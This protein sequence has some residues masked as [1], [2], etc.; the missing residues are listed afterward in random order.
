MREGIVCAIRILLLCLLLLCFLLVVL[1]KMRLRAECSSK[2][3]CIIIVLLR[4]LLLIL[5]W[6]IF[7][8][9]FLVSVLQELVMLSLIICGKLRSLPF[10]KILSCLIIILVHILPC[11][12]FPLLLFVF[13]LCSFSLTV[14]IVEIF[15][16]EGVTLS[17]SLQ[18]RVCLLE[19]L[20]FFLKRERPVKTMMLCK[21]Y[22]RRYPG[23][24]GDRLSLA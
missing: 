9:V 7:V 19:L 11:I 20:E 3:I 16:R 5:S 24:Q 23:H 2:L 17:F 10:L 4:L 18:A 13:L 22:L 21:A 15:L 8:E 12:L 1:V 6:G 14:H